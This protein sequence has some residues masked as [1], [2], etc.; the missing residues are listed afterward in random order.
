[1]KKQNCWD[2]KKCGRGPTGKND[3]SS[4]KDS[5]LNGIHGGINAGRACWAQA[6]TNGPGAAT[7]TFAMQ[8]KDCLRCDFFRLVLTEEESSEAG[9][10]ATRLGMLK[11]LQQCPSSAKASQSPGNGDID[12]DLKNEFIQELKRLSS[13]KEG[14]SHDL[15]DEF[16]RE[17]ERL[18]ANAGKSGK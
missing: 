17:V 8:L 9:F 11:L 14:L 5:T 2:F 6:G 12:A 18:S 15:K 7:G 13:E 10:S 1:M 4:T 16:A 3:C